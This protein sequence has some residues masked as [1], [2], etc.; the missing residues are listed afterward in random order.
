M[1][2]PDFEATDNES[3]PLPGAVETTP[4]LERLYGVGKPALADFINMVETADS[5]RVYEMLSELSTILETF[6]GITAEA[7][8]PLTTEDLLTVKVEAWF[9]DFLDSV[10]DRQDLPVEPQ[11]GRKITA[12]LI[13]EL[14]EIIDNQPAADV[15]LLNR[16]G[17]HEYKPFTLDMLIKMLAR[18][19]R[20]N[21]HPRLWLGK[22]SILASAA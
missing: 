4:K 10:G 16:L 11:A 17:T 22:Y 6:T 9:R 8:S 14:L 1:A 21:V 18:W 19:A 12:Q 2:T 3:L 7:G 13:A 20:N 5:D 15:E